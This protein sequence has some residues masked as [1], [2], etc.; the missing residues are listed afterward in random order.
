MWQL[1]IIFATSFSVTFLCTPVIANLMHKAGFVGVDVHKPEKP[2]IPE[3]GGIAIVVGLLM[4]AGASALLGILNS[5]LAAFVLTL[6]I[7]AAIGVVDDL[8]PL[9]PVIKPVLTAF[10]CIPIFLLHAYSSN[11]LLPFL[12]RLR[13][14]YIYPLLL[15]LAVAVTSNTVNMI[16]VLNGAVTGMCSVATLALLI[17]SLILGNFDAALMS[18]MLLGA[19]LAFHYFNRYPARVFL[20]DTGSL[21]IGAAIGA[22]AIIG[23]L[24]VIGVVVLLPCI[25]NSFYILTGLKQLSRHELWPRPIELLGDGRLRAREDPDAPITLVRTILARGPLKE[26]EIVRYLVALSALCALFSLLTAT[27]MI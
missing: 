7:A 24:E 1:A 14:T 18:A 6:L 12:G 25:M 2:Q 10:A 15:P 13:L 22:I 17:C 21:S 9:H 16:D 3:M 19:L 11:P 4:A 23:G 5:N 20:G 8:R 27:I 26:Y